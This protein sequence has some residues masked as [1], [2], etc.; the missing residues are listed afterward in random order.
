MNR[1][2]KLVFIA[3]ALAFVAPSYGMHFLRRLGNIRLIRNTKLFSSYTINKYKE[4][5]SDYKGLLK[6]EE[7]ALAKSTSD[8]IV[9]HRLNNYYAQLD[10]IYSKY[11]PNENRKPIIFDKDGFP[12]AT[13]FR[14]LV[15]SLKKG[16]QHVFG[17]K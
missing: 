17:R 11:Y 5:R 8:D 15:W 1:L 16:C 7:K 12:F 2:F 14:S 10:A 9:E 3:G 4:V 13:P 6:A